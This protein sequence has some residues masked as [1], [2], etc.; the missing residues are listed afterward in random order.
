MARRGRST[1]GGERSPRAAGT[2]PAVLA[3]VAGAA[4]LP[5]APSGS[6]DHRER[7]VIAAAVVEV[8]DGDTI[9]VVARDGRLLRV[10]LLGVD[11][12]ETRRPGTP[13]E[14][15]GPQ[16]KR[17]MEAL[18]LAGGRRRRVLVATD[19]TRP[20]TDRYGRVLAYVRTEAGELL[21]AQQLRAGWATVYRPGA[22]TP[23]RFAADRR[24]ERAARMAR[25][26]VWAA[27]GGD[28]HAPERDFAR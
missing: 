27:C 17:S 26:G 22:R 13:I 15:G 21:Q 6:R 20:R 4:L 24:E 7:G 1:R 23:P 5:W 2:L 3:V 18:A 14:C 8:V 12:P 16:A 28:F 25:R 10:R 19:P 11:A 9:R